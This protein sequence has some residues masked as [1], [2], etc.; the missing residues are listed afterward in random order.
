MIEGFP[1]DANSSTAGMAI[2]IL[3]EKLQKQNVVSFVWP[4]EVDRGID[5]VGFAITTDDK[6]D[7]LHTAFLGAFQ[8]KGI[9]DKT[10]RRTVDVG[11]HHGYWSSATPPVFVANVDT[12]T[13]RILI[14]DARSFLDTDKTAADKLTS[15]HTTITL[16]ESIADIRLRMYAQALAPWSSRHLR[17]RTLAHTD[18]A[19]GLNPS[20]TWSL[21]AYAGIFFRE[22]GPSEGMTP[23]NWY[24]CSQYF[25]LVEFLYHDQNCRKQFVTGFPAD[26]SPIA[27]REGASSFKFLL[28]LLDVYTAFGE[29]RPS[30]PSRNS[31]AVDLTKA[32]KIVERIWADAMKSTG[33]SSDELAKKI[34][35]LAKLTE[36]RDGPPFDVQYLL[37]ALIDGKPINAA[38]V[39]LH[40]PWWDPASSHP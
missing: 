28:H 39:E 34:R 22:D 16:E 8:S 30:M 17:S 26:D 7:G 37:T 15:I 2:G 29:L 10:S 14:E 38:I 9:G 21:I 11:T 3:R 31:A 6:G 35:A 23:A 18:P 25:T 32:A 1:K 27:E 36:V 40:T 5:L 4:Q 13:Q 24:E 20:S 19:N 12:V 33:Y